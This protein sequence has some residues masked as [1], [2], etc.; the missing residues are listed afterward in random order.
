[1]RIPYRS[2]GSCKSKAVKR[3]AVEYLNVDVA[4][5]DDRVGVVFEAASTGSEGNTDK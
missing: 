2:N 4:R 5:E 1:M 3:Y